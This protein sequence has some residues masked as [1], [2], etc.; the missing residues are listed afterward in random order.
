MFVL[1]RDHPSSD[2]ELSRDEK[3]SSRHQKT[4]AVRRQQQ[5]YFA[6]YFAHFFLGFTLY[7][8]DFAFGLLGPV[9]GG[10]PGL[11]P[12]FA[13]DLFG[14]PFKFVHHFSPPYLFIYRKQP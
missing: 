8:V 6:F 13:L 10:F 12:G 5:L 7:L 4:S 3:A 11:F 1:C 14:F 2:S 9:F